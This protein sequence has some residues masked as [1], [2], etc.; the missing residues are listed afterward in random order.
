MGKR[1]LLSISQQRK[2]QM[3]QTYHRLILSYNSVRSITSFASAQFLRVRQSNPFMSPRPILS[4][5]GPIVS[6]SFGLIHPSPIAI[7]T[8]GTPVPSDPFTRSG[9]S[10][11]PFHRILSPTPPDHFTR[12]V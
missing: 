8:T 2:G 10:F 12:S 5:V 9:R 11:N 3:A 1:P 4:F 7:F 6:L